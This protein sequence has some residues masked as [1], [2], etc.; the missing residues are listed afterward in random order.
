MLG[1]LIREEHILNNIP[2]CFA[3]Q[4]KVP[5]ICISEG[6]ILYHYLGYRFGLVNEE[7]RTEVQH[8]LMDIIAKGNATDYVCMRDD[9][10]IEK[11]VAEK[12]DRPLTILPAG[13]QKMQTQTKWKRSRR[14]H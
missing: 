1:K 11:L 10:E 2:L 9:R 6:L 12:G 5:N 7:Y 8:V 13:Y 3:G 14:Q 4:Y